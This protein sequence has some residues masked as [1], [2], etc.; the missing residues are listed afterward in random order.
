M[1]F[2]SNLKQDYPI[3]LYI[4]LILSSFIFEIIININVDGEIVNKKI[5]DGGYYYNM[6]YEPHV[7]MSSMGY[8][9]IKYSYSNYG[10]RHYE[11]DKYILT[12]K[13]IKSNNK[14][15]YRKMSVSRYTFYEK[16]IGE[17]VCIN[18]LKKYKSKLKS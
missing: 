18:C 4:I 9:E 5:I 17:F 1:K 12:I 7:G 3:Y 16:N 15:V 8:P 6:D 2:L 10:T 11:P 14:I 13:H